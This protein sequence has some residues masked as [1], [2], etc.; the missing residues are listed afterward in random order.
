M[1][2]SAWYRF[3]GTRKGPLITKFHP[4]SPNIFRYGFKCRFLGAHARIDGTSVTVIGD[5]D[6]KARAALTANELNF[7]SG[8]LLNSLR[9]KKVRV[10]ICASKLNH[11]IQC[12]VSL[13]I[14]QNLPRRVEGLRKAR[15]NPE[16]SPSKWFSGGNRTRTSLWRC[17]CFCAWFYVSASRWTHHGQNGEFSPVGIDHWCSNTISREEKIKLDRKN[18]WVKCFMIKTLFQ[19]E[20]LDLAPLTTVGNL[21][22]CDITQS[23]FCLTVITQPFRRLCVTL[24]ADIT[25]GESKKT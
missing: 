23:S 2:V 7:A 21:V 18:M 11:S 9:T 16:L 25:C 3:R 15:W 6:K 24:G 1:Q 13:L 12:I 22:R 14:G 10:D 5:E 4:F 17:D 20:P 8:D 19:G